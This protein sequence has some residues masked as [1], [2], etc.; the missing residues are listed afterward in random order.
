M[1]KKQTQEQKE[2][3]TLVKARAIVTRVFEGQATAMLALEVFDRLEEDID[4]EGVGAF[5][6]DLAAT[7]KMTLKL[8]GG[9]ATPD[10]TMQLF[11]TVID[12]ELDDAEFL[13]DLTAV[14]AQVRKAFDEA[15]ANDPDVV[16]GL[17]ERKFGFLDEYD[18]EFEGN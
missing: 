7:H 15:T 12:G 16:L 18:D 13:G 10:V 2:T 14:Q 6:A 9:N 4:D 17:Y 8:F 11:G 1:S 5:I 3:E